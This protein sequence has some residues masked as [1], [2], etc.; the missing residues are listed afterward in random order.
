MFSVLIATF[1]WLVVL[2]I[3]ASALAALFGLWVVVVMLRDLVQHG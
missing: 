1:G 2:L 3:A